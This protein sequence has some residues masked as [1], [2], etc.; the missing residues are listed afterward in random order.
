[1]AG[2]QKRKTIGASL[3]GRGSLGSAGVE[4]LQG[5]RD[6]GYNRTAGVGNRSGD[7][8]R[9]QRLCEALRAERGDARDQY[10][11][12]NPPSVHIHLFFFKMC[13]LPHKR[14]LVEANIQQ[15]SGHFLLK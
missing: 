2:L 4:A 12:K 6:V 1:M 8:T 10:K 7:V 3:V 13:G 5:Y 11:G 9:N 14:I 15:S